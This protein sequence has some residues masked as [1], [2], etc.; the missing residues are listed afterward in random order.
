M[1]RLST[2]ARWTLIVT[3]PLAA[4]LFLVVEIWMAAANP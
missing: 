3:L 1:T 2:A 4:C